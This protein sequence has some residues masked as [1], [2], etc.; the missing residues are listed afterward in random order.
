VPCR[1]KF[2]SE[3]I[4]ERVSSHHLEDVPRRILDRLRMSLNHSLPS[5]AYETDGSE[6]LEDQNRLAYNEVSK[7]Q[8]HSYI[9]CSCYQP[10][11]SSCSF[12]RNVR[13]RHHIFCSRG[14]DNK[15]GRIG[16]LNRF[17]T[18]E[19]CQ[20]CFIVSRAL[21]RFLEA[22]CEDELRSSIQEGYKY[23][24]MQARLSFPEEF[25]STLNT[26][27]S[28]DL[29]R[30]KSIC[31][32]ALFERDVHNGEDGG[33]AT[34]G[35]A[36]FQIG[37]SQL[38]RP[39]Q[40][41]RKNKKYRR[42]KT[43]SSWRRKI[44]DS[45]DWQLVNKWLQ[46]CRES[47]SDQCQSTTASE[48]VNRPTRVIDVHN[49]CVV[50]TP[51]FSQYLALSYVWGQKK[52]SK[53]MPT[54]T[55]LNISSLQELGALSRIVLPNTIV[56]AIYTCTKIGHRY[57]WIDSL[58]IIQDDEDDAVEQIARMSDI[59][60]GAFLTIIAAWGDNSDSG[61]PGVLKGPSRAPQRIAR[62]DGLEIVEVLPLLRNVL[63][64]SPWRTRAWTWV[65]PQISTSF[66]V[67]ELC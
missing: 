62:F 32:R 8:A 58:C 42:P 5:S 36:F 44:C 67:P 65:I 52:L 57:L 64:Y 3:I 49:N 4:F 56:D 66:I 1:K 18:S 40:S 39:S 60:S 43:F 45:V 30:R 48:P 31:L 2:S 34:L 53:A 9:S 50:E 26:D 12:C 14:V 22:R 7:T 20:L 21:F 13:L 23:H 46:V 47:H 11:N 61:L 38:P 16:N 37:Y 17:T 51:P 33:I 6:S 63:Q 28:A 29:E 10:E 25:N 24:N 35:A 55:K 54:A 15:S 41:S 27:D 59:Y 19:E